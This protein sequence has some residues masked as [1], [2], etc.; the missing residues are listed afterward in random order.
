[1]G[2]GCQ[3][4]SSVTIPDSVTS[5][6]R[7]AFRNCMY[8]KTIVIGSGVSDIGHEAFYGCYNVSEITNKYDGVQTIDDSFKSFGSV[9]T[10]KNA[11]FMDTNTSFKAA[12]ADAGYALNFIYPEYTGT[13]DCEGICGS[14]W[15]L[16]WP[17]FF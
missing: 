8:T 13:E 4:V 12:M 15:Y 3:Y 14:Q 16:L 10:E 2:Y 7:D 6:G 1:M 17:L 9:P 11:Y 5:I